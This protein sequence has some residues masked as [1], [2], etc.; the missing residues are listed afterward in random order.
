MFTGLYPQSTR[1]LQIDGAVPTNPAE[2]ENSIELIIQGRV[3]KKIKIC[4]EERKKRGHTYY[5]KA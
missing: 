4:R 3:N 2:F 5:Y 1:S